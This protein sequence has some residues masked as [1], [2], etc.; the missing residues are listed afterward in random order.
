MNLI[1]KGVISSVVV[2]FSVASFTNMS[3][4][5]DSKEVIGNGNNKAQLSSYIN[6]ISSAEDLLNIEE[7]YDF[8]LNG[9]KK[10][11]ENTLP[12]QDKYKQCQEKLIQANNYLTSL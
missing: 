5:G 12:F 2:M 7:K 10:I 3:A 6:Y 11:V 8:K 4:D 9:C 1:L